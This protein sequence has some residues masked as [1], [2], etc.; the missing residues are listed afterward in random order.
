MDGIVYLSSIL[1]STQVIL[2][3]N[4]V[5]GCVGPVRLNIGFNDS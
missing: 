2:R 4:R 1:T 3:V 5:L